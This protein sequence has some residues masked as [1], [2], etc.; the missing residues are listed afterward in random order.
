MKK[1]RIYLATDIVYFFE[2]YFLIV[3]IVRPF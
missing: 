3:D 1:Q 2:K